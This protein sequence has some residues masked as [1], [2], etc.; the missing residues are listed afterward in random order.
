MVSLGR[1]QKYRVMNGDEKWDSI[2]MSW[3][4]HLGVNIDDQSQ[5]WVY[6]IQ[7]QNLHEFAV[8]PHEPG[9]VSIMWISQMYNLYLLFPRLLESIQTIF[10]QSNST[11]L[12]GFHME[13]VCA[14]TSRFD[15]E[16]MPLTRSWCLFELLQTCFAPG[17]SWG[18]PVGGGVETRGPGCLLHHVYVQ[19]L[20]QINY[21]INAKRLAWLWCHVDMGVARFRSPHSFSGKRR[22]HPNQTVTWCVYPGYSI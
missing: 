8:I 10:S 1:V 15:E 11:A 12:E 16:A 19:I 21:M 6:S 22:C 4:C 18:T 9:P 14:A 17:A 2:Y 5:Q 3:S 13:I 20:R 7:L